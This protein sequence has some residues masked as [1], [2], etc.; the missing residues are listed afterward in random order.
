MNIRWRKLI[1]LYKKQPDLKFGD[2][3]IIQSGTNHLKI[4]TLLKWDNTIQEYHS[5]DIAIIDRRKT[6]SSVRFNKRKKD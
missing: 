2:V 6:K 1:K 4:I 3:S 5:K